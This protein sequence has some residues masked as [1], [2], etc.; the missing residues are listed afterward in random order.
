M[1]TN[2]YLKYVSDCSHFN[3]R[4]MHLGKTVWKGYNRLMT[5]Y[6]R[7]ELLFCLD[8]LMRSD[9][10]K[11]EDEY[12]RDIS[13]DDFLKLGNGEWYIRPGNVNPM[14]WF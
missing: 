10:Y 14:S 6:T 12:S 3:M 4:V 13:L 8:I 9:N 1:G 2:Y 7:E 5:D 11:I